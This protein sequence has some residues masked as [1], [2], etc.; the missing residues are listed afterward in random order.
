MDARAARLR[1]EPSDVLPSLDTA[2]MTSTARSVAISRK[3]FRPPRPFHRFIRC[4][5]LGTIVQF[6]HRTFVRKGVLCLVLNA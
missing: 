6:E 5:Q 2:R 4:R 3:T 1:G